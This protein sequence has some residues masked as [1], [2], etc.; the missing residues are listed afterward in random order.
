MT[1]HVLQDNTIN[2]NYYRA[3][4]KYVEKATLYLLETPRHH[5]TVCMK[6][7]AL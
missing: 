5:L 1:H 3:I 2:M 6:V 4:V 7:W